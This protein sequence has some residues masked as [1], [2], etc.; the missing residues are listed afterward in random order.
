M[1]GKKSGSLCLNTVPLQ[2]AGVTILISF[3]YAGSIAHLDGMVRTA[4][5]RIT[6][7]QA[8]CDIESF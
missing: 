6:H 3:S 7:Q 5:F 2:D 1:V 4:H 8:E